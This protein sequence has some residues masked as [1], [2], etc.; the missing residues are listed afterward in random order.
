MALHWEFHLQAIT[1]YTEQ[2]PALVLQIR[3]CYELH[4]KLNWATQ[5]IGYYVYSVSTFLFDGKGPCHRLQMF[6]FLKSLT[7]YGESFMRFCIA[8]LHYRALYSTSLDFKLLL[9]HFGSGWRCCGYTWNIVLAS[10]CNSTNTRMKITKLDV[11]MAYQKVCEQRRDD[12]KVMIN[13]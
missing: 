7:W 6:K 3:A 13:I 8:M 9:N 2:K 5:D 12:T 11:G 10:H 4:K 1:S